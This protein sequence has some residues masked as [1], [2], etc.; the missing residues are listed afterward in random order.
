MRPFSPPIDVG[1]EYKYARV[2]CLVKIY[3]GAID[4][5]GDLLSWKELRSGEIADQ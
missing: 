4:I 5:S 1:E 3:Y 2:K